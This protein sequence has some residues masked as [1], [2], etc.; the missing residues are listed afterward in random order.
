M[1]SVIVP[2]YKSETTL[3][4]CVESLRRQTYEEL[5]IILVDD[6]S[7]DGCPAL[8]DE[9]EK[10]DGRIRAV[11][12]ENGGVSSARNEGIRNARGEYV[13]F[14]DSD[15]YAE[16]AMA[17]RLLEAMGTADLAVCGFY[18]HY[19]GKKVRKVPPQAEKGVSEAFL[20]LYGR[21]FLN[22]P[23]NKLYRRTLMGRF[24]ESLSLGEDLLFNLDYL[25]RTKEISVVREPLCH[26][27]QNDT[28][29]TLSSMRREDKLALGKL[30][31]REA[32][33]FY[34]ELTG[35]EDRSGVINTRLVQEALDDVES[36]PFDRSRGRKEKLAVIQEYIR[37][38]ELRE[39]GK[40]LSLGLP[41]YRVIHFC[42]RR[43]W[44]HL[45]YGLCVL[46][47][48]IFR[49]SRRRPDREEWTEHE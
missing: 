28:G 8:C 46:R 13:F 20:P 22:M 37:D 27:I 47:A 4:R 29:N 33:R 9:L 23:W 10:K 45:T 7:P 40:C 3:T 2:V 39:A 38:K 15:D 24:D 26:Y 36:L 44:K 25:R 17:Q 5:E 49:I 32:D 42:M 1:I 34:R 19:V 41:D 16:P 35:H 30:V 14:L 11:H 18:H 6:G 31:W 43:G 21:G 48:Q 12:K